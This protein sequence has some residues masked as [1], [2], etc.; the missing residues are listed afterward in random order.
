MT[1]KNNRSKRL[2][3][4]NKTLSSLLYLLGFG[5]PLEKQEM[6]E[7]IP[8]YGMPAS[9]YK[10]KNKAKKNAT[11]SKV[12]VIKEFFHLTTLKQ[13]ENVY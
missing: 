6:G 4:Y 9:N 1:K 10:V 7:V 8:M 3:F 5:T 2:R 13:G 12:A 11:K